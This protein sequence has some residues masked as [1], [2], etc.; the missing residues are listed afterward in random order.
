MALTYV[1][2]FKKGEKVKLT[3]D[4]AF[5][6]GGISGMLNFSHTQTVLKKDSS[7]TVLNSK[8]GGFGS[9]YSYDVVAEN[10]TECN[11]IPEYYLEK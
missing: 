10:G 9:M 3:R 7:C 2:Q 5:G 1:A 6:E 8:N 4:L 11:N